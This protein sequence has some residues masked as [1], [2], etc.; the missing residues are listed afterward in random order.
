MCLTGITKGIVE[1]HL[2][3][4]SE[5]KSLFA[6]ENSKRLRARMQFEG[7]FSFIPIPVSFSILS[8]FNYV[9]EKVET[10]AECLTDAPCA[11]YHHH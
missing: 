10:A 6:L 2:N 8:Q 7:E 3:L 1:S 9:N 11:L 5:N 4:F